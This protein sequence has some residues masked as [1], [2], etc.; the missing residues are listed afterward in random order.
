MLRSNRLPMLRLNRLAISPTIVNPFSFKYR[1]SF[2]KLSVLPF[3]I[4]REKAVFNFSKNIGV[5]EENPT[6]KKLVE[7]FVPFYS[8]DIKK[9]KSTYTG[10]YG[11]EITKYEYQYVNPSSENNLWGWVPVTE[12]VWH[13]VS[14][15]L[16]TTDI[17]LGTLETQIYADFKYD[18]I[19]IEHALRT[20]AI[21]NMIPFDK[22]MIRGKMDTHTMRYSIAEKKM[23]EGIQESEKKRAIKFMDAQYKTK[24]YKIDKLEIDLSDARITPHSYYIPSYIFNG[25][26]STYKFMNGYT[27][28][29]DGGRIYS[30]P[31]LF[32]FST[33]I[34]FLTRIIVFESLW[35]GYI[36]M[37]PFEI[38]LTAAGYGICVPAFLLGSR[39]YKNHRMTK[40]GK[41]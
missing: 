15:V 29:T 13:R 31:K 35:H 37:A 26:N 30:L 28:K 34:S 10:F 40:L 23:M 24:H 22:S 18:H 11:I 6:C 2:T 17:P 33:G 5:L 16:P 7:T 32:A 25:R 20:E 39:I 21:S 1:R 8:I 4:T 19:R 38:I 12:I 27:S 14:G 41:Y 9:L 3:K 36:T